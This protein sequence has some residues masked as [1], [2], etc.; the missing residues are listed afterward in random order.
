MP[1]KVKIATIEFTAEEWQSVRAL[2]QKKNKKADLDSLTKPSIL[3]LALG[4]EIKKRGGARPNTGNRNSTDSRSA[5][6]AARIDLAFDSVPQRIR[7]LTDAEHARRNHDRKA[8]CNC[9]NRKRRLFR[10]HIRINE[11]RHRNSP[12]FSQTVVLVR[13][14]HPVTIGRGGNYETRGLQIPHA[15]IRNSQAKQMDRNYRGV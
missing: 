9:P 10:R 8:I 13:G 7:P 11:R 5:K 14:C 3:R 6:E 12:L 2:A 4:L 1:E 15:N